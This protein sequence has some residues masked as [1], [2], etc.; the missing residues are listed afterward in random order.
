MP[1]RI[2]AAALAMAAVGASLTVGASAAR[3]ATSPPVQSLVGSMF[4]G[5]GLPASQ[6][7]GRPSSV[8][9]DGTGNAFVLDGFRIR[10]I[11]A[12]T[13]VV[14]TVVGAP[15]PGASV[16][17]ASPTASGLRRPQSLV[18]DRDNV[19]VDGSG[20]VWFHDGA[21][22][23]RTGDDGLLHQLS[24]WAS[25]VSA[26]GDGTVV[27]SD[28]R[29][30]Y[31]TNAAGET[32]TIGG[33][34]PT[35]YNACDS[36][37]AV[38]A[39]L[40]VNGIAGAPDGSVYLTS[41][42]AVRHIAGDGTLTTVVSGTGAPTSSAPADGTSAT[43][44][45]VDATSVAVAPN[46]DLYFDDRVGSTS[47]L[48]K[49]TG[50]GVLHVIGS[51]PDS[52]GLAAS[53]AA[54]YVAC[55]GL[56]TFPSDGSGAQGPGTPLLIPHD[57]A[58]DGTPVGEAYF[59]A[60]D[61]IARSSDGT[62]L[63]ASGR[64]IRTVQQDGTLG[65]L[66]DLSGTYSALSD[67][68]PAPDGS[69][70]AL[71]G[72]GQSFPGPQRV[73][74]I[75]A[76]GGAPVV[77]AG[78]GADDPVTSEEQATLVDLGGYYHS[79][80]AL[81]VAPDGTV[82]LSSRSLRHI[83]DIT[84]DG[85]LHSFAAVGSDSL[86]WDTDSGHLFARPDAG[87]VQL[88]P[89]GT[90]TLVTNAPGS[91]FGIGS[92]G[93]VYLGAGSTFTPSYTNGWITRRYPDGTM[94][95]VA[96]GHLTA[97]LPALGEFADGVPAVGANLGANQLLVGPDDGL[98][99]VERTWIGQGYQ[100][101]RVRHI[102]PGYQPVVPAT[103][104]GFAASSPEPGV[105]QLT[106]PAAPGGENNCVE[107]TRTGD[108]PVWD[109]S[110]E[111]IGLYCTADALPQGAVQNQ[112][113]STTLTIRSLNT[114]SG[115]VPISGHYVLSDI[116]SDASG[117]GAPVSVPVDV[118]ADTTPP[119]AVTA[120][121][122]TTGTDGVGISFVPP[123]DPDLDHLVVREST[124][125]TPPATPADGSPMSL[126]PTTG[127]STRTGYFYG[128]AFSPHAFSVWAVDLAG[129][130]SA[131]VTTVSAAR[132]V[133]GPI[134]FT[135]NA[136]TGTATLSWTLP[137]GMTDFALR[138]AA[139]NVPP[140][141]FTA[142]TQVPAAWPATSVSVPGLQSGKDYSYSLFVEAKVS[143]V[144][145]P[146]APSSLVLRGT[147]LAVG[148]TAIRVTGSPTVISG[149][150]RQATGATP[151]AGRVVRLYSRLHGSTAAWALVASATS[152]STG[153]VAVT[154][155]PTL[156]TDYELAFA[157]A[158]L[159]LGS[160]SGVAVVSVVPR[161]S[162]VASR[163][164]VTAGSPVTLTAAV[165][166]NCH[167][168]RVYLQRYYS[169]AWHT[170]TSLL[171]S[172]TSR[173]AFVVRPARGTNPYRVYKPATTTLRSATSGTVSIKGA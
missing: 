3:A 153:Q 158:S 127:Q 20:H 45:V 120:L 58:P 18:A 23:F 96:G 109:Q 122:S 19:A 27:S 73:V 35:A 4:G 172:S 64:K 41:N 39:T 140:A 173:A 139:G 65:T 9:L 124:G 86:S 22:V 28:G 67:I 5:D 55:N 49:L 146:S 87:V 123:S 69:T 144:Y 1:R 125:T 6:A 119:S 63:L 98:T 31:R 53:G 81:A 83:L 170:V 118:V 114:S 111:L 141:S 72:V 143:G 11:D 71:V 46:G 21:P 103:P 135:G 34:T 163:T 105:L 138:G 25:M 107:T 76:G 79:I 169:G 66:A 171:L 75:P 160:Q 80:S 137:D 85:V 149:V 162:L 148:G 10:R 157:G 91:V 74:R 88:Q 116:P 32:A 110:P 70:Y 100:F 42:G 159:Q 93:S 155:K 147:T 82:Y 97:T 145:H 40:S 38:G 99:F 43:G 130:V 165:S 2:L 152:T 113:G 128:D 117:T 166:P 57:Q 52:C 54:L 29:Y 30:V 168:Q 17:G 26:A 104:T 84:T 77:I 167:G 108:A 89:D 8:A 47:M 102:D 164:S 161:I 33:T 129:N 133:P 24:V 44:V 37:P 151:L 156:S 48:Y 132:P 50:D 112:D 12:A 62:L 56:W 131:P 60:V 7:T 134:S 95:T 13:Q 16:D 15:V 68:E 106:V 78:G 121:T 101:S 94:G 14:S 51:T 115:K 92:D 142:G 126:N 136:A 61:H 59:D 90:T 150:L 36:C 154:V